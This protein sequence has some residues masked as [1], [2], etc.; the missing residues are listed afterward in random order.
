M[1]SDIKR[2]PLAVAPRLLEVPGVGDVETTIVYDAT[3]DLPGVALPIVGRLVALP[4]PRR[5]GSI[6]S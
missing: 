2:A 5:R 3:L 6:G 1:F 4:L